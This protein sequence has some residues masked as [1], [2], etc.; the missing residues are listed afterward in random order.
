[1]LD[2]LSQLHAHLVA[3]SRQAATSPTG[4]GE[5]VSGLGEAGG[6]L[7]IDWVRDAI[8]G[9]LGGPF[10]PGTVNLTVDT[11][12]GA[13]AARCRDDPWLR[14]F[15]LAARDTFCPALLHAVELSHRSNTT[16]ALL[17]RPQVPGYPNDKLE[18]VCPIP[19][20]A[21][22]ALT[23]GAA[24]DVRYLTVEERWP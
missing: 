10:H 4:R 12:G 11:D 6:F 16:P 1:V 17:L 14:R 18:L 2:S 23:D 19:L 8:E 13:V 21:S 15:E 7:A 9:W 20:R 3:S 22:W 5:L 24:L